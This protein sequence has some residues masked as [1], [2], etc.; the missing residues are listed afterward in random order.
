MPR[1]R[2]H[3][4]PENTKISG[5]INQIH[6]KEGTDEGSYGVEAYNLEAEL[7]IPDSPD[8]AIVCISSRM[9]AMWNECPGDSG[10]GNGILMGIAEYMSRL[11]Q[12]G[13]QPKYDIKFLMTTN[14]ENG[15]YGAQ[16]FSDSHPDDNIIMWIGTD[17]L[18]FRGDDVCLFNVYKKP[19]H[20]DIGEV[21]VVRE[22]CS[23]LLMLSPSYIYLDMD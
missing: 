21:S 5:H 14:E 23:H 15:M 18:G 12:S 10:A 13:I 4:D 20:R 2:S 17:Q 22:L 16:F 9:D 1:T 19:I 3:V 7:N 8:D 6:H 11:N